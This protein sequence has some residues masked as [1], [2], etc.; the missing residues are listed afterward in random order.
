MD[1]DKS[2]YCVQGTLRKCDQYKEFTEIE[3]LEYKYQKQLEWQQ[4]EAFQSIQFFNGLV[5]GATQ[6]ILFA[7]AVMIAIFVAIV[8]LYLVRRLLIHIDSVPSI[9]K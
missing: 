5:G 1:L 2:L 7:F 6:A 3:Y 4:T 8:V 9:F